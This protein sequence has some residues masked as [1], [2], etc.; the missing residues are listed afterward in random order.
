M[1]RFLH[2]STRPPVFR[3]CVNACVNA[4]VR[5]SCGLVCLL[6]RAEQL[7]KAQED[8]LLHKDELIA[9]IREDKER[10]RQLRIF[11]SQLQMERRKKQA[12]RLHLAE[13]RKVFA[14]KRQVR[15]SVSE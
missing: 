10:A 7:R 11:K 2:P 4:C 8:K 9:K 15:Q 1:T 5:V 6:Q 3:A 14:L 13:Q 12:E